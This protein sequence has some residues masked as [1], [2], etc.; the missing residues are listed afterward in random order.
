[1][2]LSLIV[3]VTLVVA[4]SLIVGVAVDVSVTVAVTLIVGVR[5][6][7]AVRV[8]DR[9]RDDDGD[10]LVLRVG[11]TLIVGVAVALSLIVGV[12]VALSLLVGVAEAVSESAACRRRR[13]GSAPTAPL[14]C[15]LLSSARDHWNTDVAPGQLAD[16]CELWRHA[17]TG[18]NALL[19]TVT[20]C[21]A[22]SSPRNSTINAGYKEAVRLRRRA[23]QALP[24]RGNTDS[25]IHGS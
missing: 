23:R 20:C 18:S 9:L 21:A 12:A 14:T 16:R 6:R 2:L 8:R 17:L 4:V 25:N 5:L 7:D 15:S 11:V 10:L 1:V 19:Y 24:S 22:R 13:M 3:G